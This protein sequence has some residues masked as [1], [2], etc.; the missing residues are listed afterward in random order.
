M[1]LT[2]LLLSGLLALPVLHGQEDVVQ[3]RKVAPLEKLERDGV[4]PLTRVGRVLLAA[5]PSR[6]ALGRMADEGATV[7]IDLRLASEQ[8]GFD[9]AAFARERGLTY[10]NLGF[11]SPDT[12]TDEIFADVRRRLAAH[13]ARGTGDLLLHCATSGRAG[14]VWL[15]GRVLDEGVDWK[16]AFAEAQRIG[17]HSPALEGVAEAYVVGQGHSAFGRML[18]EL[19]AEFPKVARVDVRG[20]ELELSGER[21]P[22][23]LDVRSPEEFG[24]SHL[25]G[26]RRAETLDAALEALAGVPKDTAVVAYCSVGYRSSKLAAA[27]TAKGFT[28]V[29][30]LEGSIFAWANSGRPVFR[31]RERASQVHPYDEEWGRFLDPALRADLGK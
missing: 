11:G 13:R 4:A 24:V 6:D 23:L 10:V 5:Q 3:A 2:I 18:L 1:Q 28:N 19:R 22:I 17:L 25:A 8:R 31:G 30:N 14:A 21:P 15:A 29:R 9:E 12:L 20:L 16:T 7:V 26:A 27:L